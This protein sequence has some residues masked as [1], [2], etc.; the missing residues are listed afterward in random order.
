MKKLIAVLVVLL[1]A[2]PA[3]AQTAKAP[4]WSFFGSQRMATFYIADDFGDATVNGSD[5]DWGLRWD[6]QGNS[7]VGARVKADKVGGYIELALTAT[8][9]GDGGDGG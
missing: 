8:N 9:G 7:R 4:E 5:D 2:V 1:F 3:M 6:F